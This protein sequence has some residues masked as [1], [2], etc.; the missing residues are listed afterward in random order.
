MYVSGHTDMVAATTDMVAATIEYPFRSGFAPVT[1]GPSK[2]TSEP[3]HTDHWH[4]K[5][6]PRRRLS[7]QPTTHATL[8]RW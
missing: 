5:A 7:C 6:R 1:S 4:S 3:K 8:V 2:E